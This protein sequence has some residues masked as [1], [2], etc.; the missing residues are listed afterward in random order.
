MKTYMG[1]LGSL[2]SIALIVAPILGSGLSPPPRAVNFPIS[3]RKVFISV[4]S[5]VIPGS[6]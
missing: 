5:M 1:D 4:V 6:T 3:L 2:A